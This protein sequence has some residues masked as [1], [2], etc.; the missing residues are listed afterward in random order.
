MKKIYQKFFKTYITLLA[1]GLTWEMAH[2]KYNI[3]TITI[4][5]SNEADVFKSHLSEKDFNFIELTGKSNNWAELACKAG[6]SC[7]VLIISGHFGGEFF[8]DYSSMRL[9]LF[10]IEQLACKKECQGIFKKPLEIFLFGCNTLSEKTQDHR[11]PEEYYRTLREHNFPPDLAQSVVESRYGVLGDDYKNRMRNVFSNSPHIYGFN[12][13]SPAGSAMEPKVNSYLKKIGNY[14]KHLERLTE[15]RLKGEMSTVN[16]VLAREMGPHFSECSGTELTSPNE[17]LKK[18]CQLID[19]KA[20][21]SVKEALMLEMLSSEDYLKNIPIIVEAMN[22][23]LI[24]KEAIGKSISENAF[25]RNRIL[26]LLDKLKDSPLVITYASFAKNMG[27][28]SSEMEGQLLGQYLK[29]ELSFPSSTEKTDRVCSLPPNI[30]STIKISDISPLDKRISTIPGA[31]LLNCLKFDLKDEQISIIHNALQTTSNPELQKQ[32]MWS[33]QPTVQAKM[34]IAEGV[35]RN[36]PTTL[37]EAE[38]KI[39]KK[40]IGLYSKHP[41]LHTVLYSFSPGENLS[42]EEKDFLK[43]MIKRGPGH[44]PG[45]EYAW[46]VRVAIRSSL[47]DEE[48][49]HSAYP[50]MTDPKAKR[51][52]E[53]YRDF[54]KGK[55]SAAYSMDE[56][57]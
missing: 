40:I 31:R 23:G 56:R 47:K 8:S 30:R 16:K 46:L 35:L 34:F 43:R 36:T 54:L 9:S 18:F 3:C 24:K 26:S 32:L 5:S 41:D 53:E 20:S 45:Y 48:L 28:L 44:F 14:T 37:S 2:A 27:W 22:N 51:A 6:I 10:E 42:T 57:L 38:K 55:P 39:N 52:L 21:D 50:Y 29:A 11:T 12:S 15:E 49:F 1:L 17:K 4:N 7:D 25:L 33:I 19:P 13:K